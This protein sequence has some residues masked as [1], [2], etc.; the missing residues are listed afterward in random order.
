[1]KDLV[2]EAVLHFLTSGKLFIISNKNALTKSNKQ[3]FKGK[4]L[5]FV[6]AS[7]I[8]IWHVLPTTFNLSLKK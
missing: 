1:M 2:E 8:Q 7:T 4:I 6:S 3:Y 5:D